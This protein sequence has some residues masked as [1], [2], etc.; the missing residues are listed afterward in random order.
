MEKIPEY[1]N[2]VFTDSFYKMVISKP[3]DKAANIKKLEIT[4]FKGVYQLARYEGAQVFHQNLSKTETIEICAGYLE[5]T[6]M[7]ANAW[8]A[9]FEY[10]IMI[11]KNGKP[12][13]FKKAKKTTA[14]CRLNPDPSNE[15]NRKKKYILEEGTIIQPLI[16]MGVLNANGQVIKAKY[17]KFRQINR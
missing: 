12:T 9:R 5:D 1:L 10:S 3:R 7:Q 2:A 14:S 8:D 6:F 15:H 13:F 11:S 17:D 4:P 16:D